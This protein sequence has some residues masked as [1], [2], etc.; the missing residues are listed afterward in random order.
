[1]PTSERTAATS[2]AE[3]APAPPP[4]ASFVRANAVTIGLALAALAL[5]GIIW[6]VVPHQHKITSL[7]VFLFELTPFAAAAGAI[8]WVDVGWARRLRLH[9][10]LLPAAFLAMFCFFVPRIF[11]YAGRDGDQ[12]YYHMLTLVPLI[13]LSL[14]LAYRLGGGSRG[15]TLRLSGALLLFQL[16]GL[17]DLAYILVNPHTDPRWQH[18]PDVWSWAYHMSVFIGHAPAKNEAYAFIAV[19]VVLALLVLFLPARAVTALLRRRAR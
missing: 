6:S 17:E 12:L 5:A 1:M 18:V 14:C 2:P 11:Y 15:G 19:H 10:I 4:P 8:A 13:I 7:W 9:L 16:S 3:E